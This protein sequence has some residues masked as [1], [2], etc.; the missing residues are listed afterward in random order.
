MG[1]AQ[2]FGEQT[3][4]E[5]PKPIGLGKEEKPHE[6]RKSI[7]SLLLVGGS[8]NPKANHLGCMKSCKYWDNNQAQLVSLP[9]AGCLES[10]VSFFSFRSSNFVVGKKNPTAIFKAKVSP[11][12]FFARN[13]RA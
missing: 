6:M 10:T 2:H 5:T 7:P 13:Y 11:W 1:L 4:D 9:V 3:L 8:R 12:N